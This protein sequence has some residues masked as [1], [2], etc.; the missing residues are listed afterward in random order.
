[1]PNVWRIFCQWRGWTIA[2]SRPSGCSM[3][4]CQL[5]IRLVLSGGPVPVCA[6]WTEIPSLDIGALF[7]HLYIPFMLQSWPILS[8]LNTT[9]VLVYSFRFDQH[10]APGQS[11]KIASISHRKILWSWVVSYRLHTSGPIQSK[12]FIGTKRSLLAFRSPLFLASSIYYK[13][14]GGI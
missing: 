8:L 6:Q 3:Q 10:Q 13:G 14:G 1:V 4:P 7:L 11:L 9:A 12:I 5:C 2:G